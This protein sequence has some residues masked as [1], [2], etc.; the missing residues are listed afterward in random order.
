[1]RSEL[2]ELLLEELCFL[3]S[4]G[5]LVQDENAADV[6]VVDLSKMLVPGK[7]S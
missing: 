2:F 7:A 5:L 6:I 4:D 1:M 3:I